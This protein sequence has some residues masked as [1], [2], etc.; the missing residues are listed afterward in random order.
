MSGPS[1]QAPGKQ[2][3]IWDLHCHLLNIEGRTP[4]EKMARLLE[5]ADRHSIE[6][7]CLF[8]SRT[9][10]AT[11]TPEELR[12]DNDYVLQAL[13]HWSDR[14]FGFCYVSGQHPEASVAEI[15]RCV[16]K[17]PM[18][19]I[20]LWVARRADA[21]DLDAIVEKAARHHAV[22]FQHTW[23][24]QAGNL[25]GESTPLDL[26]ALAARHPHTHFICG[27]AGG[28][29]E[30]GIRA[31]RSSPNVS[32]ELAGSDPTA[33]FTEMAVRELGAERVIFGSDVSGRSFASQLAKVTDA[34]IPDAA[35]RAIFKDNLER[36]IKQALAVKTS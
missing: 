18:V 24:K 7:L 3:P 8:F 1:E 17:G 10:A 29:W 16:A 13:S 15:D 2:F 5:I 19:G 21:A 34:D 14:A 32:I 23:F 26:V 30:L 6:R 36:R 28:Q 22:I 12:E 20:K 25:P 33:G 27:H 11:P 4:E 35:K 9:W 31:I